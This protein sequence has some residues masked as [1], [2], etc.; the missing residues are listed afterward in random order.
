LSDELLT[1][2]SREIGRLRPREAEALTRYLGDCW[3]YSVDPVVSAV[4]ERSHANLHIIVPADCAIAGLSDV[5]GFYSLG[6]AGIRSIRPLSGEEKSTEE[7]IHYIQR[8]WADAIRARLAA[9]DGQI[10]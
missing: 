10:R 2:S 3:R 6:L 8:T 7:R 1:A 9:L 4:C 5:V